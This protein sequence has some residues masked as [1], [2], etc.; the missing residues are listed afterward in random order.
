MK[1]SKYTIGF[2]EDPEKVR[3]LLINLENATTKTLEPAPYV[4][5]DIEMFADE[6]HGV[7]FNE[8]YEQG[9]QQGRK[10]MCEAVI[11]LNDAVT[12][13]CTFNGKYIGCIFKL[14]KP[15]TILEELELFDRAKFEGDIS[16]LIEK[17][18]YDGVTNALRKI[19]ESDGE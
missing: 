4:T 1:I 16:M 13:V 3:I 19:I 18:G 8:G 9:I 5:P 6:V 7:G 12:R 15:E 14:Y 10:E 11:K 2:D 17:H